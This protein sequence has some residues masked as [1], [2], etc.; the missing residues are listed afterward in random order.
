MIKSL[1][2][3]TLRSSGFTLLSN[4]RYER[5]RTLDYYKPADTPFADHV[6]RVFENKRVD[7][8]FDVGAHKG[9]YAHWLRDE[10]GFKG[11]IVS[12][13]PIPRRVAD[14]RRLA[15][16]DPLWH[17]MPVALSREL[18]TAE[19][20]VMASDAFS[21]FLKP[22]TSQPERYEES[23]KVSETIQVTVRTVADSWKELSARLQVS[24]LYLKMDTQG[25][26][27]E[28]F[29]GAAPV[30][31]AIVGLQSEMAFRKIYAGSAGFEQ[32]L[33]RF[34]AAGFRLCMLHPISLDENLAMIEA[35]GLFVRG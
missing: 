8:V 5:L 29:D 35:D 30:L 34:Q 32:A 1:I 3:K 16:A 15:D 31:D 27:L 6:R 13:E 17:I 22:D 9:A 20:H 25:F 2:F 11:H 7:C 14:L 10:V 23:N 4:S 21:S 26:D 19:F 28:V 33:A 12:F 24:R 18:G